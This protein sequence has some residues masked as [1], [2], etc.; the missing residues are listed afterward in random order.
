M[1][2][3]IRLA[4]GT[5]AQAV[6]DIY[7]P[8][9][10]GSP[11]TFEV[12]PPS[13]AEMQ[14]RIGST[15]ERYPWLVCASAN[16]VLGYAYASEHRARAAYGWSVDCSVYIDP[17]HSRR[18]MARGLYTSLFA[19]LRLQG[20]F[21]VFAGITLPNAASVGLHEAMGF[22]AV[23]TYRAVGHKLGAWH[24]VGWWQLPLQA[25]LC[26]PPSP[27]PF[28]HSARNDSWDAAVRSGI[29]IL[30]I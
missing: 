2:T 25:P 8:F 6:L 26:D 20:F 29:A 12:Q 5:D 11:V 9:V 4:D 18:G 30:K 16:R 22:E 17:H 15:I 14:R 21:N 3:T 28:A 7:T 23:G 10:S 24:D 13:A 27:I 19:L 1:K